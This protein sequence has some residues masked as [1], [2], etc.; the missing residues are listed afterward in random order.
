MND[1]LLSGKKSQITS[2]ICRH[3]H[4]CHAIL[5]HERPVVLCHMGPLLPC[6][7]P[8]LL[9]RSS[10]LRCYSGRRS[11]GLLRLVDK[12]P[13][14]HRHKRNHPDSILRCGGGWK[15]K[16]KS[17]YRG[18]TV[19]RDRFLQSFIWSQ[20]FYPYTAYTVFYTSNLNRTL[21]HR[22]ASQY[23]VLVNID[24]ARRECSGLHFSQPN[25][26]WT[27]LPLLLLQFD[28]EAS[29]YLRGNASS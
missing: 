26:S 15:L 27:P 8:Q 23:R 3:S 22:S 18:L 19:K 17:K 21:V 25:V 13:L 6:H 4:L 20:F 16:Q 12:S 14:R 29:R 5:C 24:L 7:K 1:C 10:Q 9:C 28:Y 11:S 2:D